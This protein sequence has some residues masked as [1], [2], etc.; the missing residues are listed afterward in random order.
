MYNA[1]YATNFLS[2]L[3]DNYQKMLG[4]LV[5]TGWVSSEW[6][7]L[8]ISITGAALVLPYIF[9]SP[10]ANRAVQRYGKQRVVRVCKIL[11]IPIV[12]LAVL[13]F[14]LK[15]PT[16]FTQYENTT[17]IATALV[18]L[19]I[20]LIGIQSSMYSPAKYG[21]IRDIGGIENVSKGMGGMESLSFLGMLLAT[22]LAAFM[23]DHFS[24]RPV[25]YSSLLLILAVA[26]WIASLLISAE[27]VNSDQ[28]ESLNPFAYMKSSHRMALQY[29][30]LNSVIYVLSI[31]WWFATTIQLCTIVYCQDAMGLEKGEP[32]IIMCIAAIGISLG[33][34]VSGYIGNRRK[35]EVNNVPLYG[36]LIVLGLLGIFLL[37]AGHYIIFTILIFFVGIFGGMFKVPLDAA[38]QRTVRQ[39]ELN[40]I[41]AYFNQVSFLF[42]FGASVTYYI[43]TAILPQRYVFLMLGIVMAGASAWLAYDYPP[44][45]QHFFKKYTSKK[46]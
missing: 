37:N 12:L 42:M 3:N 34:V 41:L 39:E 31:F 4:M 30:G 46:S 15:D 44:V 2:T 21:L 9:C 14:L 35:G 11:E 29:K 20:F 19:S 43:I 32:G 24:E 23:V 22:G 10:L 25:I 26:G 45:K 8:V 40:T 33:C 27:E 36:L 18:V 38:I 6:K 13:G 17:I 5:V 7:P 1:L 28:K 16:F